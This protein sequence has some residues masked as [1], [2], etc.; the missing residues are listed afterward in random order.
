MYRNAIHKHYQ[1]T[2]WNEK[3]GKTA[4]DKRVM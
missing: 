3:E 1:Y 4:S 2:L